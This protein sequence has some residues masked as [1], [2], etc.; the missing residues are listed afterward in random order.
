MMELLFHRHRLR[1]IPRLIHI[2]PPGYRRM[3]REQLQRDNSQQWTERLQC[4]RHVHHIIGMLAYPLVS[5]GGNNDDTGVTCSHLLDVA[6]DLLV[7]MGSRCDG[8]EWYVGIKQGDRAVLEF[9]CREAFGV[10][11]GDF[12]ELERSL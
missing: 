3:V 12:L 8:H 10:D 9:P 7:D 2:T 5:L 1:Q 11:V 6:H 4:L